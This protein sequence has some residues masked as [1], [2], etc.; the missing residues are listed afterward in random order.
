MDP[1]V[2][3]WLDQGESFQAGTGRWLGMGALT[4]LR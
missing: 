1:N 2:K 3:L 4:I